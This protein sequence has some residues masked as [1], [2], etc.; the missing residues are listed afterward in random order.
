[1]H[2][3]LLQCFIF[4]LV[5]KCYQRLNM[6]LSS[7]HHLP[8]PRSGSESR[9]CEFSIARSK[10]F[11]NTQKLVVFRK[12]FRSA[13]GTCLDLSGAE[14]NSQVGNVGIFGFSGSVRRHDTPSSL[15]GLDH[16]GN[17]FTDGSNLVHL[18]QQT[19]ARLFRDGTFDFLNV[20]DCQIVAHNL[21]CVRILCC[22]LGPAFPVIFIKGIF[23]GHDREICGQTL[24]KVTKFFSRNDVSIILSIQNERERCK[25]TVRKK[26][27]GVEG[28]KKSS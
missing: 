26:V 14:T 23:D 6:N 2:Q 3:Q 7:F 10:F 27:H 17:R 28:T 9:S 15:F 1:M 13:R 11:F 5:A 8:H 22:E 16:G 18:E 21:E 20:S 24:I 25:I 12:T 4:W 19:C